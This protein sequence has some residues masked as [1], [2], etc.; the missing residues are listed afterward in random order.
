MFDLSVRHMISQYQIYLKYM[1]K[2][3]L[4][5]RKLIFNEDFDEF[6]RKQ[7]SLSFGVAEFGCKSD[8]Q[9]G[10]R[11]TLKSFQYATVVNFKNE[12]WIRSSIVY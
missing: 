4:T 2:K 5:T 9:K 11:N 8:V 3:P 1:Q 12:L 6:Y 10:L 7:N